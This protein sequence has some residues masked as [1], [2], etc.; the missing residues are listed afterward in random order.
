MGMEIK[1]E[2]E[3][4]GFCEDMKWGEEDISDV[5]ATFLFNSI[6]SMSSNL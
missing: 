6:S 3:P 4:E 5:S 2:I 1:E